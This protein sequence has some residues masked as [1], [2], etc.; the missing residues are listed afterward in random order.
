[1]L[2]G[3]GGTWLGAADVSG[4]ATIDAVDAELSNGGSSEPV[5]A[6]D[7]EAGEVGIA[8]GG[9]PEAARPEAGDAVGGDVDSI[10]WM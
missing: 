6:R 4:A 1:V 10:G 2:T 5:A 7:D 9:S 3:A 8:E